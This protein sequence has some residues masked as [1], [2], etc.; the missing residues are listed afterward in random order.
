LLVFRLVRRNDWISN[1]EAQDGQNAIRGGS[2]VKAGHQ[3]K[4][5]ISYVFGG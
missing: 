5:Q 2:V 1:E 3:E 4:R